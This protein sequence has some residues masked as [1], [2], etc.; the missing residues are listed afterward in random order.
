MIESANARSAAGRVNVAEPG[1]RRRVGRAI[2]A[3]L[4]VIAG[5][6]GAGSHSLAATHSVSGTISGADSYAVTVTLSV[7]G[8]AADRTTK[9]DASG[10]YSFDDL[11]DGTYTVRATHPWFSAQPSSAAVTVDRADV[12]GVDFTCHPAPLEVYGRDMSA[13]YQNVNVA[14]GRIGVNDATVKVNG[15]VMP[16]PDGWYEDGYYGGQLTSVLGAGMLLE[17]EVTRGASK[18]TAS[19]SVPEAPIM[20]APPNGA[21]FASTDDITVTWTS[22]TQPDRFTVNADW[23]CGGSCGTGT[24]FDVPGTARTFTI[25]AHSVPSGQIITLSVFAYN[26]GTFSGDYLPHAAYPGMN[27]RAAW[28][29]VTIQR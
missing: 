23:S 18:V 19:G 6:G 3:G 8:L 5:C 24:R 1:A 4:I 27:I 21:S 9:T 15:E 22:T 7:V 10:R 29:Q 20:T 2:V 11:P 12:S 14:Q 25:P 28:D 17:I 26:N 13:S 16:H